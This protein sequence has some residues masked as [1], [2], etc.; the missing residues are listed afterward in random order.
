MTIHK[1]VYISGPMTGQPD[2]NL[3]AFNAEAA[4]LRAQGYAVIN[5]AENGLPDDAPW[6]EHMRRD[7]TDLMTCGTI[8]MLPGWSRSQGAQIERDLAVRLGMTVAGAEA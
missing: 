5:P 6:T 4:K 3:P 7:I 1:R 2:Y 8:F